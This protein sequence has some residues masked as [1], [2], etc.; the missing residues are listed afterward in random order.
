MSASNRQTNAGPA[1]APG[2]EDTDSSGGRSVGFV[3]A[4]SLMYSS[5]NRR[6]DSRFQVP[7]SRRLGA[8]WHRHRSADF[9][10]CCIAGFQTRK[11]RDSQS[12]ADLE[13]G[14]IAGLK[15]C[16]ASRRGW[17]NG[18]S[19]KSRPRR[20]PLCGPFS[21]PLKNSPSSVPQAWIIG[22]KSAPGSNWHAICPSLCR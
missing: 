14:D 19:V 15:I 1:V 22:Q 4:R 20:L 13:V 6:P 3:K 21:L 9:Q 5:Q 7:S 2:C 10:V 12:F 8:S 11:L 17:S 16:A 18:G